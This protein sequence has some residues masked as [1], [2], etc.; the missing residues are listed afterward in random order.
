MPKVTTEFLRGRQEQADQVRGLRARVSELEAALS[1]VRADRGTIEE[2]LN[3]TLA[4]VPR[5]AT[6]PVVY[7]P[8]AKARVAQPC[9][10]VLHVTDAHYG[11]EQ[12]A[13]EVEAFGSYS[14]AQSRARQLGWV[15]AALGWLD[16]H[17]SH[18]AIPEARILCTGDMIS[19]DIHDELRV[20]NAFPA[21]AQAVGAAEIIAQQAA[22]LAPH[23]ERVIVD[24]VSDDNH[25]RLTRKPQAKECGLNNWMYVVAQMAAKCLANQRNV[26]VNVHGKPRVVVPVAGRRYLLCHGHDVRGW[27]GVPWYGIERM[28]AREAVR[29][30]NAREQ[31]HFDRLVMGHFHQPLE[32]GYWLVGGS[33]SGTDAYDHKCG[34]HAEPQQVSW[35]VHPQHGEFDRTCWQLRRYDAEVV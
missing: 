18:Y 29:R 23:F 3:A 28:V 13:E 9:A 31:F 22:M 34:R 30:M 15:R 27:A 33:V 11:A 10:A 8:P 25:G 19:G 7:R 12:P 1:D 17:R 32:T 26:L 4:A 20:T 14:P 6:Q 16:M 24:I 35:L 5:M 2:L 21:P